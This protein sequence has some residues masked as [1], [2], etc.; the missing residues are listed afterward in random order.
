MFYFFVYSITSVFITKQSSSHA[1]RAL[2]GILK[3]TYV[4]GLKTLKGQNA[5]KSCQKRNMIDRLRCEI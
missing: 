1:R 2:C 4:T 5:V 3:K